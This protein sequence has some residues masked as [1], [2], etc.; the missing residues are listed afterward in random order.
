MM[1]GGNLDRNDAVNAAHIVNADKAITT[2][3]V[4]VPWNSNLFQAWH[5]VD[6]D[7]CPNFYIAG[8]YVLNCIVDD[9]KAIVHSDIDLWL[10]DDGSLGDDQNTRQFVLETQ[11]VKLLTHLEQHF[12]VKEWGEKDIYLYHTSLGSILYPHVYH[13]QLHTVW[14]YSDVFQLLRSFD[15]PNCQFAY[16]S[17]TVYATQAAI[18]YLDT[19]H[20]DYYLDPSSGKWNEDMQMARKHRLAKYQRRSY[21]TMTKTFVIPKY[22]SD[23]TS[24]H[25]RDFNAPKYPF[26]HPANPPVAQTIG[27]A[28]TTS[29]HNKNDGIKGGLSFFRNHLCSDIDKHWD[30]KCIIKHLCAIVLVV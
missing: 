15:L 16:R 25:Y 29:Y 19:L 10:V 23:M 20:I 7:E 22:W 18:R 26:V 12:C 28:K 9:D 6:W 1:I 5:L 24:R 3:N 30:L 27:K 13:I 2:D 17:Q 8:G 11:K 4:V 21:H 14:I